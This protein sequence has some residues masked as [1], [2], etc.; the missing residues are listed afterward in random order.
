MI[1]CIPTEIRIRYLSDTSKKSDHFGRDRCHK[2]QQNF[3]TYLCVFLQ[4][5]PLGMVNI[6]HDCSSPE[7]NTYLHLHIRPT[8]LRDLSQ[9]NVLLMCRPL[10]NS[11]NHRVQDSHNPVQFLVIP[12][13][14]GSVPMHVS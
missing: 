8:A 1:V 2:D 13:D 7:V 5:S 10:S 3:T 12:I 11:H 6:Y 9:D 14:V 4:H